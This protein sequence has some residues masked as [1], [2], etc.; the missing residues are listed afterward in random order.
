MHLCVH[1]CVDVQRRPAK[2]TDY[3]GAREACHRERRRGA[4]SVEPWRVWPQVGRAGATSGWRA[5][6]LARV[7]KV[8]APHL[9]LLPAPLELLDVGVW[10]YDDPRRRHE[11]QGMARLLA[12]VEQRLRLHLHRSALG[13]VLRVSE[14]VTVAG[15]VLLRLPGEHVLAPVPSL[16]RVD[17]FVV[18]P[19]VEDQRPH[20]AL[21]GDGLLISQHVVRRCAHNSSPSSTLRQA[22]AE[23]GHRQESRAADAYADAYEERQRG[24]SHAELV[25]LRLEAGPRRERVMK[26]LH[27]GLSVAYIM[28]DDYSAVTEAKRMLPDARVESLVPK[29]MKGHDSKGF[30]KNDN[31]QGLTKLQSAMALFTD[32]EAARRAT[33]FVGTATSNMGALV[34]IIRSQPPSTAVDA[35]TGTMLPPVVSGFV[36]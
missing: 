29:T 2:A 18:A 12:E 17:A 22:C 5:S 25:P 6:F 30:R 11:A 27:G 8:S 14:H 4:C 9:Q 36:H 16:L 15:G 13:E 24:L 20:T 33:V 10:R 35:T 26:K 1:A 3:R 7:C 19:V 31:F 21:R 23:R 34:Q 28:S 32:L